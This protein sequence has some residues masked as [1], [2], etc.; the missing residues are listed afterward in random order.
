[1]ETI[2]LK[3]IS[4]ESKIALL[5]VLGYSSDGNFIFD[6]RGKKVFDQYINEAVRI[7]NML[8]L[9]GSTLILDDNPLSIAAYIEEYGDVL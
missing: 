4:K 3:E 9:P 2:S 5:E 8:I 6:D 1:M 7:E